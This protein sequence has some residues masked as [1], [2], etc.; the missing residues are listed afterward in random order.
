MIDPES[1]LAVRRSLKHA[2]APFFSRFGRL[3]SIQTQA[4]PKILAGANVVIASPTATGKT[5]AVVAPLAERFLSEH[6]EGLAVLYVVPTRALANDSLAR[7]EGPLSDMG[8]R[9]VLRHGDKPYIPSTRPPNL[10]ITTPES[11]DSLICRHA[12]M[13]RNVRA[14]ILDEIHLLDNTYRGDQ[15][16]ILLRRL[17]DLALDRNFSVYLMSATLGTPRELGERYVEA[18]DLVAVPG[19]REIDCR[20][21]NSHQE[22]FQLAR[23]NKWLKVLCFCNYRESV[24]NL[25]RD[26]QQIWR[27]Y[28]VVAHHGSLG[29]QEREDAEHLMK[30][31]RV[32]V[33]VATTT[34]EIGIDIGDID[35]VVLAEVP[36]SISSLLQRV[37]RG[38]R[39]AGRIQVAAIVRSEEEQAQIAEMLRAARSGELPTEAYRSDP[40][41]GIQQIFSYLYGRSDGA[42]KEG[43]ADLLSPLCSEA[44]TNL[45]LAQL[46]QTGWLE[47]QRGQWLP[48]E[49]LMNEGEAGWIHSN[50]PDTQSYRVL[51]VDSGREIG[52]IL[53]IFDGVFV[54]AHRT[55]QVVSVSPGII[56]VRRAPRVQAAAPLFR[57]SR[58]DGA[59]FRLL[60]PD[61]K[62]PRSKAR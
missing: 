45:I 25:A 41:V 52:K 50:I 17:R 4:I 38:N 5:E 3:T 7:I 51:D 37:G 26:L 58:N 60:P 55:W 48:A 62:K 33:C 57:R 54:L 13:F 36:W 14:V 34:L 1:V 24:E 8:I 61:L 20:I 56:K 19:Q 22:I 6:W 2:W 29:R 15:L 18:F 9:A 21:A 59:F 47:W 53:G 28:P 43:I 16:R 23:D 32:A 46:R 35:L 27:P 44:E 30:E 31:A 40:S 39:R 49:K 12:E 11:L 10:L 42:T